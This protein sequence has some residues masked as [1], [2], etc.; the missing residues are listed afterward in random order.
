[1]CGSSFFL[2]SGFLLGKRLNVDNILCGGGNNAA[3]QFKQYIM[4]LIK[5][6]II[7]TVV[8]FPLAFYC[9]IVN[10]S[11]LFDDIR[12]YFCGVFLVGENYHS[13]ILWYLLSSIYALIFISFLLK[14]GCDIEE[15][16][17]ISII[18]YM[19]GSLVD[20]LAYYQG[21]QYY[22]NQLH[23][24]IQDYFKHG[25]IFIG[26]LYLT[27]GMCFSKYKLKR[28]ISI[29]MSVAGYFFIFASIQTSIAII[30]CSAGLFGIACNLKMEKLKCSSFL[31]FMS[32]AMYFL[33]LWIWELFSK[34]VGRTDGMLVFVGTAVITI[35][36]SA[37][38]AKYRIHRR[39]HKMVEN[40]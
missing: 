9:A 36:F 30:I 39:E 23:I 28:K 18:V 17:I 21:E 29:L 16:F 27:L 38:Y 13:W 31:R 22:L 40:S 14:K 4:K 8:Y 33:H 19:F 6:Y 34:I 2:F 32:T 12:Y 24:F 37:L 10:D 35:F 1:M 3:D 15:V 26:M 20:W 5:L 7:W 11:S 25:R